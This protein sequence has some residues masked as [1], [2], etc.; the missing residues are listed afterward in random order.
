MK[1]TTFTDYSLR[2]LIYLAAQD[3]RVTIA[4]VARAYDIS[5]HH[6]V[7]IAHFL[8]KGGWLS[9]LRG[10]GG[11]LELARRPEAVNIGRLVRECEGEAQ[12][13]ACFRD[14]AVPCAIA[15]CCRMQPVLAQALASFYA[16]LDRHSLA[17]LVPP[18]S[19]A[20][21]LFLHREAHA[22]SAA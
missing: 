13:A 1:L 22:R 19:E 3:R 15:G 5:E 14:D 9:N 11:G 8:G 12:L 21:V 2:M 4:E 6:L 17:D 10:K 20:P 16:V 18:R 7:K